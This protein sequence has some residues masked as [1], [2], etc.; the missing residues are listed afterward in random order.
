MSSSVLSCWFNGIDAKEVIIES[1][2]SKGSPFFNIVGLP[3]KSVKESKDRV[4]TVLK[5]NGWVPMNKKI[6][7]NLAPADVKK[8]GSHFDLPIA[9]SLLLE[10]NIIKRENLL[11]YIIMG[12]LSLEGEIRGVNGV[13]SAG[14][15]AKDKEKIIIIPQQ[16]YYEASL[17]KGLKIL[18]FGNIK[19]IVSFFKGEYTPQYREEEN[20]NKKSSLHSVYNIDFSEVAGQYHVKRALE[21]SSAGGHN[22]LMVG[23]PGSGKSMLAKRIPTILPE[24]SL[25]EIIETTR[26][27]SIASRLDKNNPFIKE[28]PFRA[29]HHTISD[30]GLIG[31]GQPPSPGEVSLSHN[32]VLF[33]DEMPEFKR[34]ALEVLR[35]P[36]ED[37]EVSIV[38]ASSSVRFPARFILIG[39][40]N[41]CTDTI[42]GEE[43]PHY[44]RQ[45]YYNRLSKPLLDR[46]DIII[47]VPRVKVEEISSST[48][49]EPSKNI[50]KRVEKARNLQKQRFGNSSK[51]NS[52]MSKKDIK[53]FINLSES[54]KKL[55]NFSIE[56]FSLSARSYDKIIKLSRT[57]ADIEG[58]E[59]VFESHIA[60]AIQYR[61]YEDSLL[62]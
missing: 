50:K 27:Y 31:G 35:Q 57:I 8:T 45:R 9:L 2:I 51:T 5:N 59:K 49:R 13:L 30:I 6:I 33:L 39:A 7:V 43:C 3:E 26:I 14:V 25:K 32:G 38:R 56:K 52:L 47:E 55:L 37:R 16:N 4:S 23:P 34:S 1:D 48:Q 40:M 19:E 28:R 29:P 62:F 54:S 46:I 24:M 44:I 20:S 61:V 10:L 11:N 15:F 18:S 22:V 12:E 21:I 42:T 53:N 36:L 17:I 58:E 60:E 41:P